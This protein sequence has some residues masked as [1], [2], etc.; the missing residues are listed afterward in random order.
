M[1]QDYFA[2]LVQPTSQ[3]TAEAGTNNTEPVTPLRVAQQMTA[4]GWK[5]DT[6]KSLIAIG[7]SAALPTSTSG[8]VVTIGDLS[9]QAATAL[10]DSVFIGTQS[11]RLVTTGNG[12]VAIGNLT[13]ATITSCSHN[14]TIGDASSREMTT[15]SGNVVVGYVAATEM[16][17]ATE[18]VF[19]GTYCAAYATTGDKNVFIGG[20]AGAHST[21][22]VTTF[23]DFNIG[24]GYTCMNYAEGDN[25]IAMGFE[26]FYAVKGQ[27]NVAIGDECG[28]VLTHIDAA[29]NVFLGRGAGSGAGVQKVDAVNTVCIGADTNSEYDNSVTIGN[30]LCTR[31]ILRG[32]LTCGSININAN[33]VNGSGPT[34]G[35]IWR[36]SGNMYVTSDTG[37]I[38]FCSSDNAL[39]TARLYNDGRFLWYLPTSAA[40]NDNGEACLERT[41]NTTV[42]LKMKG[43]D[44]TIRSVAFTLS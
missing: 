19:I 18:N 31:M 26:S 39:F 24:I 34:Q 14:V 25:N 11:G 36:N 43:S 38:T 23:G 15:G 35:A 41:S 9:V 8:N 27:Y 1:A 13:L 37:S 16:T 12:N 7:T 29:D 20:Y 42:T 5:R 4:F 32:D 33:W 3:A 6:S 22:V 10:T 28:K 30:N 40:P 17:S 2:V 44:G 21:G